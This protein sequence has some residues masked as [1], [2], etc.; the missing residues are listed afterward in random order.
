MLPGLFC[1]RDAHTA[2]YAGLLKQ[3]GDVVDGNVARSKSEARTKGRCDPSH[4]GHMPP[5]VTRKVAADL[6]IS[7]DAL[8]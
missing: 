6:G 1:R 4:F 7:H 2:I 3:H 5:T 8:R